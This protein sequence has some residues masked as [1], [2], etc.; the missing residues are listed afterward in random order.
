MFKLKL[1]VDEKVV[2][3]LRESLW[4][5]WPKVL[6]AIVLVL[7]PFFFMFPLF[8]LGNN[9]LIVFVIALIIGFIFSIRES[10]LWHKSVFALT[11][12]KMILIR[13]QG[14]FSEIINEYPLNHLKS[15]TCNISG[16]GGTLF[17]FGSLSLKFDNLS[18]PVEISKI[19]RPRK[20]QEIILNYYDRGQIGVLGVDLGSES[21]ARRLLREM[22]KQID[23]DKLVAIINEVLELEIKE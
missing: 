19:S 15:A 18:R 13:R 4:G 11:D 7:C 1:A 2:F 23:R 3:L 5:R 9:G 12:K 16:V 17:G 8:Y 14:F 21:D 6:L 10:L 22:A 20:I